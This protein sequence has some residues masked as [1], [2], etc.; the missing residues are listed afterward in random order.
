MASSA[1]GGTYVLT[2]D[3]ARQIA[4]MVANNRTVDPG[5][6]FES[7]YVESGSERLTALQNLLRAHRA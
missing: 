1:I 4:D 6:N 7:R 5:P 3:G 2:N